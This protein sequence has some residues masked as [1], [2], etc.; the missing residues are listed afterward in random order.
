MSAY[1]PSEKAHAHA[2]KLLDKIPLIDGHNDLP[3]IIHTHPEAR[4]DV[5]KYDIARK[6]PES[7]TDIPRLREGRV[8]AQW[9]AAFVPTLAEKPGRA[10]L[11]LLDIINQLSGTYPDVFLRATNST[12]IARAKRLKK[13]ASFMPVE[14]G[15][16]LD[17]SLGPL[18]ADPDRVR[19]VTDGA[20]AAFEPATALRVVEPA[21]VG[22]PP[23]P[24]RGCETRELLGCAFRVVD[25]ALGARTGPTPRYLLLLSVLPVAAGARA[26]GVFLDLEEARS[27]ALGAGDR[28]QLEN[29][30]FRSSLSL[31]PLELGAVDSAGVSGWLTPIVE[32]ELRVQLREKGEV[33]A[34]EAEK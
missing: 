13:I 27:L 26:S 11:E 33:A 31:A 25:A 4:M 7:D 6:H 30:L 19:A 10:T 23:D 1:S 8:S 16:G 17:N 14:G 34:E 5:A 2:L 28:A 29:G 32:S 21:S 15:V 18:R 22:L 12:D 9:W 20:R 3:W 24:L